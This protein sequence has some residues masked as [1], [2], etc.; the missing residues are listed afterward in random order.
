MVTTKLT[1]KEKKIRKNLRIKEVIKG[2]YHY[3]IPQI[4][5]LHIWWNFLSSDPDELW[6]RFCSLGDTKYFLNDYVNKCLSKKKVI[7][8]DVNYLTE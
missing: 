7:Y 5:I 3:F 6:E 4:K 2:K 8:H 1:E